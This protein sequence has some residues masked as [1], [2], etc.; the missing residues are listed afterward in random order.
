MKKI[1]LSP[2]ERSTLERFQ[3]G[4]IPMEDAHLTKILERG[5]PLAERIRSL[6]RTQ[7]SLQYHLPKGSPFAQDRGPST[8]DIVTFEEVRNTQTLI[9]KLC[10]TDEVR[11]TQQDKPKSSR[12]H[13]GRLALVAGGAILGVTILQTLGQNSTPGNPPAATQSNDGLLG[14]SDLPRNGYTNLVLPGDLPMDTKVTYEVFYEKKLV[15]GPVL[16]TPEWIPSES[17]RV[18]LAKYPM[19]QVRASYAEG[20]G[21]ATS[22]VLDWGQ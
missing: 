22:D 4:E 6:H 1:S 13:L 12:S 10:A 7:N 19:V 15:L 14:G 5:G 21:H 17:D 3:M 2:A 11:G 18:I 16:A 20:T 8:D 9:A